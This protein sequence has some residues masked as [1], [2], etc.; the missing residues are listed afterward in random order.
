MTEEREC[1]LRLLMLR[2]TCSGKTRDNKTKNIVI[3]SAAKHLKYSTA[4]L[5]LKLL[6]YINTLVFLSQL[7]V[8]RKVA[9]APGTR[10]KQSAGSF[11]DSTA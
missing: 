11:V 1:Y 4:V 9:K 3:L 10:E 2:A 6:S 5:N 7:F 8:A